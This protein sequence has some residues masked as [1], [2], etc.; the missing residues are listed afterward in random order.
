M[1][2]WK[3]VGRPVIGRCQVSYAPWQRPATAR[4][5]TFHGIM[6]ATGCLCSFSLLM[7]SGVS[8]ETCW[9]RPTTARPTT[10][11][12]IMQNRGCLCSF[13]LLM[14]GGVL[15]ETC[16]QRPTTAR[17]KP[18]T[19]LCKTEAACAVLGSWW[20]AVC[21]P[22]H[23]DNVQQLHVRNLP[24]YYANQRLF[25]QF[26]LLMVGGVSP[27]T[28]WQRPTTA[29]PTTFHGIMQTRGCFCSFS[30][31]MM[32][33]VSPETCWASFKI[34]YNKILIHCCISLGFSL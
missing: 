1:I 13:R 30:L 12:V 21:R 10:F 5:T 16:W 19:L 34:R 14:V 4:P 31:L 28:C 9:Q 23:V 18:S 17:P 7:V 29:L 32:G 2:P 6:Q 20:W 8:P 24:R 22:K 26:C 27:E 25:V 11:H 15:P 3:V 33:C